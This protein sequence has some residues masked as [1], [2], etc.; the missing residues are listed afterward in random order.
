M[1]DGDITAADIIAYCEQEWSRYQHDCSGFVKAVAG[2]LGVSLSGLANEL[3]DYWDKYWVALDDGLAAKFQASQGYFVVAG[4][5]ANPHG[6]VVVVVDGP[7]V[8]GKYPTAYWGSLGGVGKKNAGINWAWAKKD[9]DSVSYYYYSGS[10][11]KT[12]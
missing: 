2:D 8:R 4:L 5:K 10:L 6:H 11:Q 3:V 7:L 12:S 1:S 9:L